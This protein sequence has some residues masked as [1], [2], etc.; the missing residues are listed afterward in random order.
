C[1]VHN[2]TL[3][4]AL[5][6]LTDYVTAENAEHLD[7][8]SKRAWRSLVWKDI[9]GAAVHGKPCD[10]VGPVD[11]GDSRDEPERLYPSEEAELAFQ[12][13]APARASPVPKPPGEPAE[14]PPPLSAEACEVLMEKLCRYSGWFSTLATK[15]L[16]G[17]R[18]QEALDASKAIEKLMHGLYLDGARMG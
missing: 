4:D 9:V 1:T 3:R 6:L 17:A 12:R 8:H 10:T 15:R 7:I 16:T 14:P 5:C 11:N 2:F 18:R 13:A